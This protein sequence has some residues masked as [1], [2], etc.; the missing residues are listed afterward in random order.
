[1]GKVTAE[2]WTR[3]LPA[4][5]PAGRRQL[6]TLHDLR[7]HIL[8]L[9]RERQDY[10]TWAYAGALVYEASIGKDSVE[11]AAVAFRLARMMDPD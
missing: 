10:L 7:A 11:N 9:P 8:A 2:D 6:R 4:P 3:E 1:M 5:I